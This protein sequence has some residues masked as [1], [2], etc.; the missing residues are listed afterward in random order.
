MLQQLAGGNLAG[1]NHDLLHQNLWILFYSAAWLQLV[2]V[3][4][5]IRAQAMGHE[6]CR[7]LEVLVLADALCLLHTIFPRQ[8][9]LLFRVVPWCSSRRQRTTNYAALG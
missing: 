9:N 4:F 2:Q 6:L 7:T 1:V 8:F 3:Q 5:D